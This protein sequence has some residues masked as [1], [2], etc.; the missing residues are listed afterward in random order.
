MEVFP[1]GLEPMSR[2]RATPEE[3]Y[4][5]NRDNWDGRA[6]VHAASA[7][8]DL[9]GLV[10]DPTRVSAVVRRDLEILAPHLPDADRRQGSD[11]IPRLDG[12]DLCHLQC[13]IGTDT[14]GLA[15]RGA[16]CT[17]VDLSP[18]SLRIAR[19]LAARAGQEIRYVEANV[20]DAAAAVG[21]QFDLVHTS[22]GT[23][24][25]L[26]D[27]AGWGRQVAGLLR[28]GGTFFFRDSHPMSNLMLDT[29]PSV[30][31]PAYGYF[32]LPPGEV[33]TH[34][35]GVTYTDGDTSPITQPRNYEWSHPVSETLMALVDA[36]LQL[37]EV[38]EHQDLP[39]PQHPSMTVE[40]E[41]WVLPEPWRSQ[42]PVALSVVARRPPL[43]PT[44]G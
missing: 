12:L 29:D 41:A 21:T 33:F 7:T 25:W 3:A 9:D 37:V 1:E 13:H 43:R 42:V 14:L 5:A 40:G 18:R 26:Q 39:W 8:Y 35:D 32:P 34:D 28:P 11:G 16:R 6:Q 44:T 30:M 31:T 23:I 10:S 17:G 20:L 19:D 22:I 4:A 36:G 2:S 27:L 15:R 24:C 38:G